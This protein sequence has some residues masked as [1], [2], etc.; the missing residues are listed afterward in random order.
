MV[1][2]KFSK[3]AIV[4]YQTP[5]KDVELRVRLKKETIWLNAQQMAQIFD[6]NRPAIVKHINNIYRTGELSKKSTCSILEQVAADGKKR[7]MN[8]Y[9]LDMIIAVGY[10]V[11]S[12][13]A[14][15]FRIW[16]TKVLKQ[17]ILQGYALNERRL[18]EIKSKFNELKA[19]IAFLKDK[20]A[21]KRLVGQEKEI[22]DLLAKYAKTL[23]ILEDYDKNKIAKPKGKKP[24]FVLQYE[25]CRR[26]IRAI[27]KE[28]IAK[29][30]ASDL[31]G[32]EYS[33]G[34]GG[35]IQSIYQTFGSAELYKTIEEKAAHLLYL[36]IKDHPFVDGNKRIGS[37]LFVYFLDRNNY[38]YRKNGERKIS[39]NALTALALLIAESDP[40]EKDILIKIIVNLLAD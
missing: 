3:G 31:F 18:L 12:K 35:I 6:V 4:I 34:F 17:Y 13:R 20:A 33:G 25:E 27:K 29:K 37:F 8:F 10:R 28:L 14:T 36:I 22:L 7:K 5:H 2:K 11:N 21:K 38:L 39:D 40:K 15:Q 26:I 24:E 30:E 9:N 1:E 23:T 32:K 19:A 16:A